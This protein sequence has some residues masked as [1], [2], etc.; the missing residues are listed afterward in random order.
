MTKP[1]AKD[2]E[3]QRKRHKM[4]TKRQVFH[5]L[6]FLHVLHLLAQL[7]TSVGFM[8]QALFQRQLGT[9]SGLK[10]KQAMIN[11]R[12]SSN[13]QTIVYSTIAL[14]CPATLAAN[15]GGAALFTTGLNVHSES[16]L[17]RSR[18]NRSCSRLSYNSFRDLDSAANR[19]PR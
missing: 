3:D 8:M 17:S 11:T 9:E 12:S 6:K 13:V 14:R 1:T 2:C 19:S 10:N 7:Y 4:M 18:L 5:E 15:V 16:C